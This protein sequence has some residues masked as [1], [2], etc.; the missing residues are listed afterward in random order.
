M[1]ERLLR[2]FE[3]ITKWTKSVHPE[4]AAMARPIYFLLVRRSAFRMWSLLRLRKFSCN[5]LRIAKRNVAATAL[6]VLILVHRSTAGQDQ[7][8]LPA[9]GN[10]WS[11]PGL[12]LQLVPIPEGSFTL[13][14]PEYMKD[15][16]DPWQVVLKIHSWAKQLRE[17]EVKTCAEAAR[18]EGITRARVSQLWPLWRITREQA[19]PALRR[20]PGG[21]VSLRNLIKFVR[22]AGEKFG[23][24]C[25]GNTTS[26]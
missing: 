22:K 18:R 14:N 13:G 3:L 5:L 10:S 24:S 12:D 17:G 6:G 21:A 1:L 8:A 20:L 7:T 16:M 2:L 11:I 15:P 26:E 19:E 25:V 9:A 4:R 23:H